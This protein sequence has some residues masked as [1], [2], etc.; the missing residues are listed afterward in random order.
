MLACTDEDS[1]LMP[2]AVSIRSM[3]DKV[4]SII[5]D[6]HARV[7]LESVEIKI[8]SHNNVSMQLAPKDN[9]TSKALAYTCDCLYACC[10]W[11]CLCCRSNLA[12]TSMSI[13]LVGPCAYGA[14]TNTTV[15]SRRFALLRKEFKEHEAV[16]CYAKEIACKSWLPHSC[17]LC[18]ERWQ[19][20][21]VTCSCA[22]THCMLKHCCYYMFAG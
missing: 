8:P 1:C 15:P 22:Q 2:F 13:K 14:T 9:C 19:G 4:R 7:T 10:L 11:Y 3:V 17:H 21:Y 12:L 16:Q 5:E 20:E 6:K 18:L